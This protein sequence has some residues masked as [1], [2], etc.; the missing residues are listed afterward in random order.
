MIFNG[1]VEED[2]VNDTVTY[3]VNR[4]VCEEQEYKDR[5]AAAWN[6]D[7][8]DIWEECQPVSDKTLIQAIAEYDDS[9]ASGRNYFTA[10]GTGQESQAPQESQT[11]RES[12]VFQESQGSLEDS[13]DYILPDVAVRYLTES[14]IRSLS[15][16]EMRLARNEV[17]ARHGRKFDSEDLQVYFNSK[18]WYNGFIASKDF[19]E[20]LLNEYEIANLDLIRAVEDE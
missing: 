14:E 18:P 8:Y 9:G 19:D 16:E 5:F 3:E 1:Y 4:Q 6:P 2:F 15:K 17:Y 11:F 12:G 20:T 10:P 13:R 7:H